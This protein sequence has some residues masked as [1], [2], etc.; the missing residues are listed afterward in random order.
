MVRGRERDEQRTIA[1]ERIRLLFDQAGK[2]AGSDVEAATRRV[3]QAH[4]IAL[5]CNV[6]MPR[7]LKLRFCRKCLTYFNSVNCRRR[8]NSRQ[9]RLELK[10]LG[11][12]RT[13][14]IPYGR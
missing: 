10:C 12:G 1:L 4:R 11:C 7:E 14:Y 5:R 6:R 3:G 2:L 13:A 8:L 9:H